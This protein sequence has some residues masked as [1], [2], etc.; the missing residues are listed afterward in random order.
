MNDPK[1]CANPIPSKFPSSLLPGVILD[2]ARILASGRSNYGASRVAGDARE[3]SVISIDATGADVLKIPPYFALSDRGR[4]FSANRPKFL[5]GLNN[6]GALT[7]NFAGVCN[8]LGLS[9]NNA[10]GP[11]GPQT[12]LRGHSAPTPK[13]TR[14][15]PVRRGAPRRA[16]E[17]SSEGFTVQRRAS[18]LRQRAL[19]K[20]DRGDQ[21]DRLGYFRQSG[22]RYEHHSPHPVARA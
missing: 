7:D 22:F 2:P 20:Y 3:G 6:P 5:N 12:L 9:N 17:S 4:M 10:S 8:P 18:A 11:S 13:T 16:A 19:G 1:A 15:R 14:L 21:C